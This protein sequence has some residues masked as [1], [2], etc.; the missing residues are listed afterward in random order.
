MKSCRWYIYRQFGTTK[1][2]RP[3]SLQFSQQVQGWNFWRQGSWYNSL[4][5]SR[6]SLPRDPS[7]SFQRHFAAPEL[8]TISWN[9]ALNND[10]EQKVFQVLGP[11]FSWKAPT[12]WTDYTASA[13]QF[14]T[15]NFKD[16][17][18]II[19]VMSCMWHKELDPMLPWT[20]STR[21]KALML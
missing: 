5:R 10:N 19:I 16:F 20:K 13:W 12:V 4:S 6:W 11:L 18:F 14:R 3:I 1:S 9:T 7:R 8:N 2:V 15:Q 21:A 17:L